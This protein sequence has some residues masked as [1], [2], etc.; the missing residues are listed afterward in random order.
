MHYVVKRHQTFTEPIKAKERLTFHVGYRS[1]TACPVFSQHTSGNKFKSE[2]FLP[3]D[4][5]VIATVYAPVTFPKCP[6]T[7]MN[8]NEEL[9]ATGM[10]LKADPNR[11]VVKKIILSAHPYKINKKTVVARYM[12]FNRDD[13]MWFKPI[14]LWTKHGR[15]VY[16]KD[17]PREECAV[18]PRKEC[19]TVPRNE[20]KQITEDV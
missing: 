12:F 19:A 10:V 8:E 18:V 17:V 15:R 20:Y 16:C 9:V 2:R 11:V 3:Y 1:F 13:V 6:V 14:E 5:V 7:V 4:D